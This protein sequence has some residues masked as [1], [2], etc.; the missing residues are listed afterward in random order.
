MRSVD[1]LALLRA[2]GETLAA[3]TYGTNAMHQK[4]FW[5]LGAW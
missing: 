5:A 3:L 1:L 2:F 4:G